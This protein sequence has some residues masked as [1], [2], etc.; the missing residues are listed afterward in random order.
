MRRLLSASFI[1]ITLCSCVTKNTCVCFKDA[2]VDT[3]LG[4]KD[5]LTND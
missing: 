2:D 4:F 5:V 3:L 1:K